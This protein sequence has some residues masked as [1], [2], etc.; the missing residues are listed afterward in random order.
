M[1]AS[2]EVGAESEKRGGLMISL[3]KGLYELCQRSIATDEAFKQ[4]AVNRNFDRV[5]YPLFQ[6]YR[7]YRLK[8]TLRYAYEKSQFYQALFDGAGVDVNTVNSLGDL[9]KLPF[10][11]PADIARDSYQFLCVSQAKV[12]K[13]VTYTS[14]GTTG[15]QKRVFFTAN[16]LENIRRFL[17]V[18]MNTVTGAD[19]VIQ[20]L[21][22]DSQGRGI[23]SLLA[24]G[25]KNRGMKAYVTGMAM[26][27]AAQIQH[28]IA[29]KPNIWFG[30]VGTIY[31]IT[32]EME[33][34]VAL[35]GLG[36]KVMFLT[37]GYVSDTVVRNLERIWDCWVCTHYG[38]TEMGWG[39]AVDCSQG[40]GFHYNE[41]DVI[42][43]VVDPR[44]GEP[45]PDGAEGELVFTSLG[46]EA[47]PLVRYRSRDIATLT[48]A[49][50]PCGCHLQTMGHVKRRSEG[51]I[52]LPD[53]AQIYPSLFDDLVYRFESAVDYD[54]YIDRK[55]DKPQLI[56][57]VKT[58]GV[59]A[60]LAE[61]LANMIEAVPAVNE[62]MERVSV[63]L[64]PLKDGEILMPGKKLIREWECNG[65]QD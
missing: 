49:P 5:D 2:V 54:I 14:T 48:S 29:N 43:E 53:G 61:K 24:A 19:G 31:R 50:C 22:P 35:A 23:G 60:G 63:I 57:Q 40:A 9:Y 25:L 58:V 41:F 52:T 3:E 56:F 1:P 65:E 64:S 7:L 47:M 33:H 10:T 45:L 13:P 42:A 36:V 55:G 30:D 39:L 59:E 21:L 15:P 37:M 38:L 8:K 12:E 62:N 27:S 46:R 16:D 17:G 6:E 28:T 44:T 26:E 20:I 34:K 18:G 51:I 4:A 32:K 11:E